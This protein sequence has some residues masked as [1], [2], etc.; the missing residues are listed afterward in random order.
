PYTAALLEALPENADNRRRLA[1]IE[2]VVPGIADR[3][4]GCLFAP[5]CRYVFDRC[6]VRPDMTVIEGR[7]VRCHR[8][9]L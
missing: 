2:G 6:A 8:P 4:T 5:R 1:V 3:P 9:L 7:A